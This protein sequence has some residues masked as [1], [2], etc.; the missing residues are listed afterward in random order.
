MQGRD[1]ALLDGPRPCPR[2]GPPLLDCGQDAVLDLHQ[3]RPLV[4]GGGG[5]LRVSVSTK[6]TMS[7]YPLLFSVTAFTN[8]S[9]RTDMVTERATGRTCLNAGNPT[10][11]PP[12]SGG[13][14]KGGHQ[15]QATAGMSTKAFTTCGPTPAPRDS[16]ATSPPKTRWMLFVTK[17]WVAWLAKRAM[18]VV[19]LLVSRSAGTSLRRPTSPCSWMLRRPQSLPG[20]SDCKGRR[21]GPC[22]SLSRQSPPS[23]PPPAPPA[24]HPSRT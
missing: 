6:Y 1:D 9:S 15:M 13:C 5:S 4:G 18:S 14:F 22:R 19:Q 12:L 2:S 16:P 24:S 21:E 11:P 17:V 8:L 20:A 23:R 7:P 3:A 10:P